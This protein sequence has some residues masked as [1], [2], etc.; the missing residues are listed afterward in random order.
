MHSSNNRLIGLSLVSLGLVGPVYGVENSVPPQEWLLEQIR[1]GEATRKDDLIKQSLYR[2]DLIAPD[3]P[4]VLGAH[5]RQALRQGDQAQ[6]QVLLAEL[7][8]NAPR[9]DYENVCYPSLDPD[10]DVILVSGRRK[11]EPK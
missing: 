1:V 3:S 2:L 9:R 8:Q 6:A 4:E 11:R 7:K 10:S 5:I